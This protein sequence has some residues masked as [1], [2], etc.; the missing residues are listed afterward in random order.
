MVHPIAAISS[1]RV[2]LRGQRQAAGGGR[3]GPVP[4][5]LLAEVSLSWRPAARPS[6]QP[7]A[8][9]L[10]TTCAHL[11]ALAVSGWAEPDLGPLRIPDRSIPPAVPGFHRQ[12]PEPAL[13]LARDGRAADACA[14]A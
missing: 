1:M 11:A 3:G 8:P 4:R 12:R 6:S 9:R 5:L 2:A 7:A 10:A 14:D 13:E